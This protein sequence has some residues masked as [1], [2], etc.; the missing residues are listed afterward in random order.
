LRKDCSFFLADS[1]DHERAVKRGGRVVV[2]SI[3]PADA[4]GRFR[5][6]PSD[7]LTPDR[8][9]ERA[10]AL[11]LLDSVFSRLRSEYHL[12]GKGALFDR[13]RRV[14]SGDP[15]TLTYPAIA[16]ELGT[17][18]DAVESA[19]RRLRKR[20]REALREAITATV[21]D[22]ADVD[23]EIHNLFAALSR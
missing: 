11:T 2:L 13:L 7:D 6:E 17:T 22:P 8:I 21:A 10:W 3:E 14:L 19:S 23:D 1:R 9:F 20:Y 18:A 4:E 5:L 16:A 12:A 15:D